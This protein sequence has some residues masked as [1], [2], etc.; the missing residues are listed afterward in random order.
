MLSEP[1][2]EPSKSKSFVPESGMLTTQPSRPHPLD[3][4]H[5]NMVV[6]S[7]FSFMT[8]FHLGQKMYFIETF[9]FMKKLILKWLFSAQIASSE[10]CIIFMN[11]FWSIKL[12]KDGKWLSK[13]GLEPKDF[14]P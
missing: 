5:V 4:I 1:G 6:L 12:R 7:P 10:K 9:I 13:P 11:K 3:G 14:D 2:F 8:K